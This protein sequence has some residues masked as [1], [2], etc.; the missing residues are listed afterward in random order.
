MIGLRP[1]D[2]GARGGQAERVVPAQRYL[3]AHVPVADA[4]DRVVRRPPPLDLGLEVRHEVVS[5]A[6]RDPLDEVVLRGALPAQSEEVSRV[7]EDLEG[8]GPHGHLHLGAGVH[9]HGHR[10]LRHGKLQVGHRG[11]LDAVLPL[12]LRL[13]LDAEQVGVLLGP[14]ARLEH[15][16]DFDLDP[17]VHGVPDLDMEDVRESLI[18]GRHL[19]HVLLEELLV[20]VARQQLGEGHA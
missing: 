6:L 14:V 5:A 2:H 7:L 18:G 1:E 17:V 9:R 15:V 19:G 20:L 16:E 10:C 12:E 4:H 11:R 13:L 3:E 8:R